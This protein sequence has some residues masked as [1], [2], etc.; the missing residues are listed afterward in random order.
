MIVVGGESLVDLIVAPD[1]RVEAVPGGG[2]YNTA[3]TIARLGGEVAFLGRVST[4]RFGRI[5]RSR[6]EADGVDLTLVRPTDAPTTL[7]IAELDEQGTAT[8][9]FYLDGTSARQL[10][11][12]DV[13]TAALESVDALHVGT[14]GLVVE[15]IASTLLT[16]TGELPDDSLLMVDPNCRPAVIDD[17]AAYRD[18]L[19]RV[20]RRADVVK[21][22]ADDL[23]FIEPGVPPRTAAANLLDEGPAVVLLTD[24]G[25]GVVVA[26]NGR[27]AFDVPVPKVPVVDTVGTGDAFGGGF[28]AWWVSRGLG[29]DG[30]TDRAALEAAV[31]RAIEVAGVVCQR[32]GAEPPTLGELPSQEAWLAVPGH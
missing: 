18:R 19:R 31:T 25:R 10:T 11:I 22:S 3:R 2:P 21:V 9:R 27:G 28:L 32:A 7:A 1:G 23:D 4:D 5:L 24:G 6:L 15:P 30:L 26:M 12:E 20:L 17:P 13:D 29:R 16:L 8:Y 14:L